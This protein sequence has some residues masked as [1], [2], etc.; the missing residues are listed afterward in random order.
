MILTKLTLLLFASLACVVLAAVRQDDHDEHAPEQPVAQNTRL[1]KLAGDYT[2][3]SVFD[4]DDGSPPMNSTGTA[5]FT[6]ILGGRF[7][8]HEESGG[9]AGM[10]FEALKL[11]GYNSSAGRYEALWLYTG[12]TAM[13]TMKGASKDGGKTVKFD[14]S[15]VTDASGATMEFEIEL[16]EID[17]N[18]FSIQL[19]FKAP[20][21]AP[22]AKLKATYTRKR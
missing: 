2:W 18:R 7:L 21:G 17:A 3:T 14:A 20:P 10:P 4:T 13:M 19:A 15:Y 11:Y 8:Q 16:A 1:A 6:S 12:S 22:S 9:M 5:R